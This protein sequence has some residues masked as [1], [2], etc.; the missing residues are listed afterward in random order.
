MLELNLLQYK[1]QLRSRKNESGEP[2][3]WDPVRKTWLILQPEE[4]VRQ[5]FIQFCVS[6]K[7]T[8][9]SRISVE[10]EIKVNALRRRYDIAIHDNTGHPW[11]LVE[12]KAPGFRLDQSVMDQIALYNME[13]R[14]P[15]LIVTNGIES[16]GFHIHF[17]SRSF[18]PIQAFPESPDAL[19]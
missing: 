16:H 13:L 6:N 9:V 5:L 10:R 17:D 18:E 14:V 15:Y 11:L 4:L 12:C 1:D 7:I 8:S 2:Q 3:L 19:G